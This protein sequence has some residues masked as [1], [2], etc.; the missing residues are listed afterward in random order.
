MYDNYSPY[1]ISLERVLTRK[2]YAEPHLTVYGTVCDMTRMVGKSGA[3]DNA[4]GGNHGN[5][6][7]NI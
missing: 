4:T 6:K 3:K 7:T 2:S 1:K 5:H